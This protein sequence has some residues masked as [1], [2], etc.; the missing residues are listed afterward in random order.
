MVVSPCSPESPVTDSEG[1]SP[2][3]FCGLVD[4]TLIHIL[5][6][7]RGHDENFVDIYCQAV[8]AYE[9]FRIVCGTC[10][11]AA[12]PNTRL[13]TYSHMARYEIPVEK[14]PSLAGRIKP[15]GRSKPPPTSHL[16]GSRSKPPPT[17]HSMPLG[18]G[19]HWLPLPITI[20]VTV[21]H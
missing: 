9:T 10:R 4:V 18:V 21:T 17:S 7:V 11:S 13:H 8:Y 3:S 14:K 12:C 19:C 5:V 6:F 2:T 16:N 1:T 20:V 15:K